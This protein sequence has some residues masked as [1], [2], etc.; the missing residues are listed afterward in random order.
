MMFESD[1]KSQVCVVK[2]PLAAKPQSEGDVISVAA[3][4][5]VVKHALL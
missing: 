3:E 2:E 4:P 1:M 5:L